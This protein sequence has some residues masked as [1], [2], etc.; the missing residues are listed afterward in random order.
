M[1]SNQMLLQAGGT[2]LRQANSISSMVM[3]LLA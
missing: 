1:L 3:S 2:V